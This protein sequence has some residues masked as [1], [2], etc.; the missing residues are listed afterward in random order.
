MGLEKPVLVTGGCGFVGRHVVLRLLKMGYDVWA[1]DD[2]SIGQH[3]DLWLPK[4]YISRFRFFHQDIKEFLRKEKLPEFGDVFH[5]AAVVGGRA[6]IE[7]NPLA[8]AQDLS[9]DAE[10]FS[11]VVKASVDR[12]LYAS[13]SAAYPINVQDKKNAEALS[14][15]MIQFGD[16]LGQ[17]DMTYGWSKLTGEYLSKI[18]AEN[19]GVHIACIR[20]FSGYGEDQDNTYPVPAIAERA[21][22]KEDP[23]IIWGSGKQGRDFV[24][25]ENC[26]DAMF[27]ILDKIK[28]GSA[29]NIGSGRLMTFEEVAKKFAEIA[30]YTPTIKPLVD[31]PEGVHTRYADITKMKQVLGWEPEISIDEGFRRVYEAAVERIKN[32]S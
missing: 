7:G 10:F 12:V 15:E 13:S 11:W 30:G 31:K 8:V 4:E 26:V 24:H 27:L 17:P 9:I 5:F 1:V 32:G 6:N 29:I 28:D 23:L 2:L 22:R 19:Y 3:P 25:I 14:E 20:P 21:A 18:A 16:I